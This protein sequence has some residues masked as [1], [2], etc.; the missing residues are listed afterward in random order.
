MVT[1]PNPQSSST[2]SLSNKDIDDLVRITFAE[3]GGES[4]TGQIAVLH[5]IRTRSIKR[6]QSIHEVIFA[7]YQFQPTFTAQGKA[8]MARLKPEDDEYKRLANLAQ[9]VF[10]GTIPDPTGGADHFLNEA[11][12]RE[13]NN[14]V[15]LPEWTK[16][17][18]SSRHVIGKHAFYGGDKDKAGTITESMSKKYGKTT[19]TQVVKN[20]LRD[21][22]VFENAD[23]STNVWTATALAGVGVSLL[24]SWAN[25]DDEEKGFFGNLISGAASLA[26]LGGVAGFFISKFTKE[27]E[28]VDYSKMVKANTPPD[29]AALASA[30]KGRD[31]TNLAALDLPTS[32]TRYPSESTDIVVATAGAGKN[33]TS[34]KIGV[35][36]SA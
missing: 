13:Q 19:Y 32:F 4:E 35:A 14:R 25:K 12:T 6:N 17:L 16:K 22:E 36:P 33:G 31:R 2:S 9:G 15:T 30:D 27:P 7:P 21:W 28:A 18:A 20:K 8:T 1:A 34:G 3:A 24:N 11:L 26:I 29:N 23:G 10:N 5:A